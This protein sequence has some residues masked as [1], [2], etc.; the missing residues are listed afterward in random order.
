MRKMTLPIVL[1]VVGAVWL[2]HVLGLLPDV[3]AV[4]GFALIV[5]GIAVLV[6][7]G[8]TKS[9]VVTGPVLVFWGTAWL[10]HEQMD[11]PLRYIAP[12]FLIVLGLCLAAARLPGVPHSRPAPT[13]KQSSTSS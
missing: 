6:S 11:M 13:V 9:S 1:I 4:G 10:A 5:A 8:I 2:M 3:R 12:V 7:E